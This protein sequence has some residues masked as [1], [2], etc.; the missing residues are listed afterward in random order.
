MVNKN[1]QMGQ[2]MRV[3]GLIIR[4]RVKGNFLTQTEITTKDNGNKTKRMATECLFITNQGL[5]MKDIGKTICNMDQVL[6]YIT[7]GINMRVCLNRVKEMVKGHTITQLEKFI[8]EVGLME[9]LKG[10]EFV[11]GQMVKGLRD[12][13]RITKRMV[14]E[15]IL[16]LT[17]DLIKGTIETIRNMVKGLTFGLMEENTSDNGR[18]IRG[19]GLDC[20]L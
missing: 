4:Q 19:M 2:F 6:K 9:G 3:N 8:K 5:V 10:M 11:R 18:T 20:M 1:G 15:Y 14:R 7:M 17:V 16:G 13:G 12:S